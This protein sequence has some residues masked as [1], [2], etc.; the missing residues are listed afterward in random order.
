MQLLGFA[1]MHLL[2]HWPAGL[3]TLSGDIRSRLTLRL[4][5]RGEVTGAP[6]TACQHQQTFIAVFATSATTQSE[7]LLNPFAAQSAWH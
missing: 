2:Q 3:Q 7:L 6:D 1:L 4:W 5:C